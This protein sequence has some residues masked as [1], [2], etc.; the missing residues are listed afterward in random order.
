MNLR[1]IDGLGVTI[2]L[3]VAGLLYVAGVRPL[4]SA[5][6]ET[7]QLKAELWVANGTLKERRQSEAKA[8][9][10]AHE[11][12]DRLDQLDIHL[13]NIDQMNSRLA[14]LTGLA[15]QQGLLIE[16]LR[17]G[18][19]LSQERFRAVVISL[20]G[21]SSYTQ[22][23]DFLGS[24]RRDFPDTGLQQVTLERIPGVD[25]VA[26]LQVEMVWYAAPAASA[27]RKD[28]RPQK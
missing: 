26:R 11:L 20:V 7:V 2:I 3:G 13:S 6:A 1:T 14:E 16:S 5:Y 15:E 27:D 17:P 23:A 28:A 12:S 21:R 25:G 4:Q 24:L 18:E 10:T 9:T 22:A 8:S 19:Q